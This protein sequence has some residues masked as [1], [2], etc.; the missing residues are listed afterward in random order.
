MPVRVGSAGLAVRKRW[1]HRKAVLTATPQRSAEATTVSPSLSDRPNSSQRSFFRNPASG[2]PVSALKLLPHFLQ[3]NVTP[4]PSPFFAHFSARTTASR[5]DRPNNR[6]SKDEQ[7]GI[8]PNLNPPADTAGGQKW[9][10]AWE[11]RCARDF[12]LTC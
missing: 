8:I 9:G 6:E 12:R 1:R 11:L 10:A 2:A 7:T 3:R 5:R 4:K